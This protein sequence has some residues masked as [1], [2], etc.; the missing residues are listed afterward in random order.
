ML[1]SP[2]LIE[3]L[4]KPEIDKEYIEDHLSEFNRILQNIKKQ[5]ESTALNDVYGEIDKL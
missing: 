4:L 1:I 2:P 3:G 5:D